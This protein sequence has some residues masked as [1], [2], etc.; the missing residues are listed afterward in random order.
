M[1]GI[2]MW[3]VQYSE[4]RTD[5]IG[6]LVRALLLSFTAALMVY[7]ALGVSLPEFSSYPAPNALHPIAR[8]PVLSGVDRDDPLMRCVGGAPQRLQN[9]EVNFAGNYVLRSCTCGSGCFFLYMW[10]ARSG[11]LFYSGLPIGAVDVGPFGPPFSD[12][13][14]KGE[15]FRRNSR[16]LVIQGCIEGTCDCATWYFEWTGLRF[17]KI[18]SRPVQLPLK[19][20]GGKVT[21]RPKEQ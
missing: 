20:G 15:D 2:F 4:L 5:S 6:F 8:P 11:R 21:S 14:Y 12:L 16:L 7:P 17:R 9:Q 3:H 19:C 13:V 10:D 1:R 18:E